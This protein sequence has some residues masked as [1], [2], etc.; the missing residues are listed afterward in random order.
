N[1]AVAEPN[2]LDD[3]GEGDVLAFEADGHRN[4]LGILFG[5]VV[6]E[7]DGLFVDVGYVVTGRRRAPREVTVEA[8][9]DSRKAGESDALCIDRVLTTHALGVEVHVPPNARTDERQVR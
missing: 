1:R 8:E 2:R 7:G 9:D 4:P 5:A 6:A 3:G